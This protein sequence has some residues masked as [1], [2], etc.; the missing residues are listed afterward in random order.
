MSIQNESETNTL[1]QDEPNS[2]PAAQRTS[3]QSPAVV[4][5]RRTSDQASNCTPSPTVNLPKNTNKPKQ[6]SIIK[7]KKK[8]VTAPF[9]KNNTKQEKGTVPQDKDKT[10]KKKINATKERKWDDKEKPMTKTKCTLEAE[11]LISLDHGSTPFDIFQM[12]T[13][14]NEHIE[15]IVTKT[16]RYDTQ[17][18]HNFETTEDDMKPFLGVNV[19]M[20]IKKLPS[21]EYYWSTDKCIKCINRQIYHKCITFLITTMTIKLINRTN[22]IL[23]LNI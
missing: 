23:L 6:S 21:S 14:M 18:G 16:N 3:N 11:E 7:M 22:S 17:K 1:G 19:I 10:K 15:I 8:K 5:T 4:V 9:D 13:G 20:G 12:V 2:V